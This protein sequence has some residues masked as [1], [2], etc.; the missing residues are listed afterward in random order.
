MS[1]VR[2]KELYDIKVIKGPMCV[3]GTDTQNG[4]AP[5]MGANSRQ[6]CV[7]DL[8]VAKLDECL[9]GMIVIE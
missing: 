4:C 3:N 1:R 9:F 8:E 2:F 7:R 6:Y 5:I